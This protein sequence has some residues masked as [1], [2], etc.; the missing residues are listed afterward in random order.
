MSCPHAAGALAYV[1]SLHPN[2]SPAALKSALMTTARPLNGSL[3]EDREFA[4]G[5]GH[6]N[7]VKAAD[8]GLIYDITKQDY[9]NV[10]CG[11]YDDETCRIM[12]RKD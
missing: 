8:P 5:S 3:H 1:K 12:S 11:S 6:I 2:W 9:I 7:P 4:Y 10:I